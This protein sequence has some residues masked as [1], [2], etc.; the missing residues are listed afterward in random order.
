MSPALSIRIYKVGF[1][2]SES[3]KGKDAPSPMLSDVTSQI[4]TSCMEQPGFV[5]VVPE[6]L[7]CTALMDILEAESDTAHLENMTNGPDSHSS[8]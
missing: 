8:G 6:A 5:S 3:I 4:V 7:A 1:F 2:L